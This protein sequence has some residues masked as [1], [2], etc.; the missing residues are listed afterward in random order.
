MLKPNILGFIFEYETK[1]MK[2]NFFLILLIG[3]IALVSSCKT[4]RSSA[5]GPCK[6]NRNLVGYN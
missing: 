4:A 5:G 6:M 3:V 1:P 2:K